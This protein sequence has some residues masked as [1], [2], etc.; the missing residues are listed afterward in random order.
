MFHYNQT[1]TYTVWTRWAE[2]GTLRQLIY[3]RRNSKIKDERKMS[4]IEVFHWFAVVALALENTWHKGQLH[5]N[6]SSGHVFKG[7]S[8]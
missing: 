8:D 7:V 3:A 4:E 6:V 2:Q 1:D 5:R